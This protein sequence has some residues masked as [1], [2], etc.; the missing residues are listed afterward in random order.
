[1]D[2]S[3]IVAICIAYFSCLLWCRF[4]SSSLLNLVLN[5]RSK[6]IRCCY[7]KHPVLLSSNGI[8]KGC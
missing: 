8:G 6:G 1:M 3:I 2:H 4:N 5:I 7:N